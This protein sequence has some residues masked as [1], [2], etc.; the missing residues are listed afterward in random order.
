VAAGVAAQREQIDAAIARVLDSG[1]FIA[2][3][4]LARFE[5]RF[6]A[7]VGQSHCVGVGTGLDA[8]VLAF[9]ALGIGAGDEVIVPA[10]TF[11]A[12]WL[13][14]SAVGADVVPVDA[15]ARDGLIDLELLERAITD[16]TKCVVPVHLY[17][18]TV[19]GAPLRAIT[20]PRGIAVVEDAAQAHLARDGTG[21]FV[22]SLG[23]AAAF[24]F[25][26]GKNLGALG[27][28]GAVVTDD[29]ALADHV[30]LLRNYGSRVKYE[31]EVA[32]GNSRLDE[33][34]AAVLQ[35]R[36]DLLEQGNRRRR[37]I[38]ARYQA[39]IEGSAARMPQP[40][41][42]STPV[43][44]LAPVWHADRD[45]LRD[46][47]A[48]AGIDTQIHYPTAPHHTGAYEAAFAGHRYPI[49]EQIAAETLSLPIGP[50]MTDV[51]VDRVCE[52]VSDFLN[53]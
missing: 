4:E 41:A 51:Q 12:T 28:G 47:L 38:A 13:A 45:A 36:L 22:G 9:R 30:R 29:A 11:I 3:P 50:Q 43:W 23:T 10:N 32:G 17:G 52:S 20:E 24:S 33:L 14:V 25:Y 39:V 46:H 15:A 18:L 48:N 49:A 42:G 26:P 53:Q 31:H 37:E 27:D 16:R 40:A 2:G 8:L 19:D 5:S 1:W 44:H 7:A 35:V 34:Q 21:A 6:A